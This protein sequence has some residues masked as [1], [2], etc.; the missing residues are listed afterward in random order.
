MNM[1]ALGGRFLPAFTIAL[2]LAYAAP[3][4]SSTNMKDVHVGVSAP[5]EWNWDKKCRLFRQGT[6]TDIEFSEGDQRLND[7]F[8]D[9]EFLRLS[10][11]RQDDAKTDDDTTDDDKDKDDDDDPEARNAEKSDH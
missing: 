1:L 6:Q 2:F 11:D 9:E 3:A 10:E 8:T 5:K 7:V 4:Q